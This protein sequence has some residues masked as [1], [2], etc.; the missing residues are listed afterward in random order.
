MSYSFQVRAAL[1]AEALAKVAEELAKVVEGQPVHAAD[2]PAAQV[3]A[4]AFVGLIV[5]DET[6][7]VQV[8]VSGSLW[9]NE[10]GLQEASV[11]VS[12]QNVERV[13]EA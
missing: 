7:D 9:L 12:A 10:T 13:V 4:E 11:Q 1:K 3:A 5:D 6:K 8:S 2:A